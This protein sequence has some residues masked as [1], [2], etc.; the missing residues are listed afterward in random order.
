MN[1]PPATTRATL[2][3]AVTAPVERI[4]SWLAGAIAAFGLVGPLDD[5]VRYALL[6]PGKRARPLLAVHACTAAGGSI[7]DARPAACAVELV[8]AFSLVHD[9]LPSLD[10]DDTR[11]GRP[12]VHIRFG[13]AMAVLAGDALLAAAFGILDTGEPARDARLARELTAATMKM[14]SG[15]VRDTIPEHGP[16]RPD[17]DRLEL[18]HREKTGALIVAAARMGA[19]CAPASRR[20][21]HAL[22]AVT[23]YAE[24]VGLMFQIVDDLLDVEQ[25]A[26]HIGKRSSKDAAAGKLTYPGVFGVAGSRERVADLL[27]RA[28]AAADRVGSGPLREL[29]EFGAGRTR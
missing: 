27:G 19:M 21:D 12:T 20:S 1:P 7:E 22:A 6:G 3:G 25:P 10:N 2:S 16:G 24:A 8:H 4:E 9:D 11:R 14:I 23:E 5:A 26:E 29:A 28:T 18:I 13:E 15:Q 17:P